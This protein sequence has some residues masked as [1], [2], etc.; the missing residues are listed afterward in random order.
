MNKEKKKKS[1]FE[2]QLEN[3]KVILTAV[4]SFLISLVYFFAFILI[5][6]NQFFN[7]PKIVGYIILFFNCIIVYFLVGFYLEHKKEE[8]KSG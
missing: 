7:F 3:R 8:N 1:Y 4:I 2:K 5:Y 6:I